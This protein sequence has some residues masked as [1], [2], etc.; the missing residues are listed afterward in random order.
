[1]N[2]ARLS[3][4]DPLLVELGV[5][6]TPPILEN[7]R[8][9]VRRY[10]MDPVYGFP[11]LL[12]SW[13]SPTASSAYSA[14]DTSSTSCRSPSSKAGSSV[15]RGDPQPV[16]PWALLRD[17]L[18]GRTDDLHGAF[19]RRAI[20]LPIVGTF[21]LGFGILEDSGYLPGSR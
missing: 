17:F 18:V 14:R 15:R 19:L 11:V 6:A 5:E 2:R 7:H 13:R 8:A 12:G 9:G 1:V 4:I 3:W 10:A 20:V 16:R 21:F